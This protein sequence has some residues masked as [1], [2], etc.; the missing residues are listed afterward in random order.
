MDHITELILQGSG[1]LIFVLA[2][3]ILGYNVRTLNIMEYQGKQNIYTGVNVMYQQY[4]KEN[5]SPNILTY[6]QMCCRLMN[7]LPYNIKI[8]EL[9]IQK[10]E[11]DYMLFDFTT[12]PKTNYQRQYVFDING[13]VKEVVYNSV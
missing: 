10:D 2:V 6:E 11:F 1:V 12:L 5:E 4:E 8:N 3:S 13:K 7:E 9:S